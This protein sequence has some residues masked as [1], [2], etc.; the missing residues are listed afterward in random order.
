MRRARRLQ[1]RT[2][3]DLEVGVALLTQSLM[4]GL[5]N[6]FKSEACFAAR[7]NPFRLVGSLS[8]QELATLIAKSR[9][10]LLASAVKGVRPAAVYKRRGEPCRVCGAAIQSRKQGEDARTTFWCPRCQSASNH[11]TVG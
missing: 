9:E 2:R 3:P 6:I 11:E 4:A 7:V 8:I 10:F 5:G 1:L